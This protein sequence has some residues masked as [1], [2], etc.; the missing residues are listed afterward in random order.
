M[1]KISCPECGLPMKLRQSKFGPFYG[2]T[3][4]P[5]CRGTA[6]ADVADSPSSAPAPAPVSRKTPAKPRKAKAGATTGTI[7]LL[8]DFRVD[9]RDALTAE[10]DGGYGTADDQDPPW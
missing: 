5:E 2:C 10:Y 7:E 9:Y 1:M 8:D 6:S 3:G 4:Y